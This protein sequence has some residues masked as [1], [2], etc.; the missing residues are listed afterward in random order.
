[1]ELLIDDALIDRLHRLQIETLRRAAEGYAR[2]LPTSSAAPIGAGF[3]LFAGTES[4]L[5]QVFGFGHRVADEPAEIEAFYE[6][7]ADNWEVTVTPFTHPDT[8]QALHSRGYRPSHFEA[9]LAQVVREVPED[10]PHQIV[11][12]SE[13]DA[14]WMETSWRAW[15]GDEEGAFLPDDLLRAMSA[16][17][18]RRYVALVDGKP[19]ATASLFQL[20]DGAILAGAATRAPYRG[21]GLQKALLHRRLRDAGAGALAVMG[22]VPGTVSHR[23]AQRAG[24]L[25]AYS[26]MIWMRR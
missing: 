17:E 21:R 9:T 11:E 7:K 13:G 20:E 3:A 15:S 8:L 1:M 19:A 2:E 5:T 4:P 18:A 10:G 26:S 22:A 12:V 6:G 24:F 14:A 25:P 16:M 23:N